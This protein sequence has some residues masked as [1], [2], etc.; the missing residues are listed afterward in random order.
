MT[1]RSEDVLRRSLF[2]DATE[3]H[4]RDP[5]GEMMHDRQIV[6]DQDQCQAEL[7]LQARKQVQDLSLHRNV[8]SGSR[9]ITHKDLEQPEN[10]RIYHWASTQHFAT[11]LPIKPARGISQ[12]YF[13]IAASSMLFRATLDN[14]DNWVS[15]RSMPPES[16]MPRSAD[17]TLVPFENWLKQFPVIQGVMLP[18]GPS[19]LELMDFGEEIDRGILTKEPPE[20]ISGKEY[21]VQVPAVDHD[22]NE[23]AGIRVPM[24]RAPL[25][26]YT[27]WALRAET[28]G[29][30]AL[31]GITGS[32]IPFPNCEDERAQLR[33]P[34]PS[35]I[36]RYSN[37]EGY[38]EAIAAAAKALITQGVM[39]EEDLPRCLAAAENWGQPRHIVRL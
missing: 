32:Y 30:G 35:I 5:I 25:G 22:G 12:T 23:I 26:T 24:V 36:A 10:L 17:G 39:L 16:H 33:D 13:N 31:L 38:Q 19:R 20:V 21:A 18:R 2:D 1:C 4:D 7:A 29:N 6:T 34:R 8:E 3:I 27:G 9:L 15:G 14:L 28:F 37:R 11:P